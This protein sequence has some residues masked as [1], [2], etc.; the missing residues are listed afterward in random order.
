MMMV[1]QMLARMIILLASAFCLFILNSASQPA[2]AQA[3][4]FL[5]TPYFGQKV[6]TS[7]CCVGH[8]GH[9]FVLTY[10]PVL[11]AS[12]GNV[13][14]ARWLS[15]GCHR[16]SLL[17]GDPGFSQTTANSC[18]YGLHLYI[19]HSD[20]YQTRYAHLSVARF[21]LSSSD[22]NVP[23]TR[24]QTIGASGSTGGQAVP[25]CIL[26]FSKTV[27]SWTRITLLFG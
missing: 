18:G 10:E 15:D 1:K 22:I 24:G 16:Y 5:V 26:K 4:A 7:E 8:N 25:I 21:A 27:A 20:G 3:S 9:D 11:A 12:D 14:R 2:Q 6:V 17:P 19:S 13:T 23:V